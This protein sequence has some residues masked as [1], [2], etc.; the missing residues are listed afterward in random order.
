MHA[1][2]DE[3]ARPVIL[4]LSE[5]QVSDYNGVKAIIDHSPLS[6]HLLADRG[7]DADWFRPTIIPL[8]FAI[9][10]YNPTKV[11]HIPPRKNRKTFIKYDKQIYKQRHKVQNM[12]AKF[13]V[14]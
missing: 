2:C 7:Y 6:K 12:F 13:Y 4:Y 8:K 14:C 1:V 11:R 10:H 9:S 5:G 3:K